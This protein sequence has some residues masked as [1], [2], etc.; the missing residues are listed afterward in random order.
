[1]TRQ[2][3]GRLN[4]NGS[5]DG[6]FSIAPLTY[7]STTFNAYISD[8]DIRPDG[9]VLIVGYF[10]HSG[11]TAVTNLARLNS[12]GTLDAAFSPTGSNSSSASYIRKVQTIT[13]NKVLFSIGGALRRLNADGTTDTSFVTQFFNGLVRSVNILPNGD[14]FVGGGFTAS[15]LI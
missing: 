2:H 5:I 6:S 3:L 7:N 11:T 15:G 4:S 1:N 10:S 8:I 14:F 12:N 9:K 13:G